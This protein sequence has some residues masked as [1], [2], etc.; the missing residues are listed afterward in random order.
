MSDEILNLLEEG[1]RLQMGGSY[2]EAE[3][4]YREVL[5]REPKNI[6]ALNLLGIVCINTDRAEE[7]VDFIAVAIG[8]NAGD[9]ESYT[10][11]GIAQKDLQRFEAARSSFEKA[12]RLNPRNP[13]IFNNLG[14]VQLALNQCEPAVKSF[15]AALQLDPNYADSL[16]NLTAALKETGQ[17]GGALAAA[18]RAIQLRPDFAEA[19]N[20]RGEVLFKQARFDD[21]VASYRKAVEFGENYVGAMINLSAALKETGDIAG[22]RGSL[23]EA[24]KLEPD[25]ARAYNN[26]GV[27]LEQLGDGAA[28]AAQF[29]EAIQSSTEYANAYYQLAQLR[30]QGLND[31]EVE[32]VRT[33]MASENLADAQRMPLAFAL[34]CAYEKRDD[35]DRSFE[36]L[37]MAQDIKAQENPYDDKMVGK[38]YSDIAA[39][40][41]VA[42]PDDAGHIAVDGPTPVFVLGMP[43][44]GTTLTE[45][46]LGSH[47]AVYGAGELSFMEDTVFE[48]KKITGKAYPHCMEALSKSQLASLGRLYLERIAA[49][50][51]GEPIVVDKTPM[52]F[53]Y[54]GFIAA[55]LPNARFIHC[56]RD[57]IDNCLSIFKLPFEKSHSYAHSLTALGQYFRHYSDLMQHWDRLLGD[58]ILDVQYENTVADVEK[59]SRS[60]LEFLELPFDDAVLQFHKAE[61]IV[62]TPSASQVR[63][64][65][66]SSSVERWRKYENHLRPLIE[67]LEG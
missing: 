17:L 45:Q 67:Q 30:G 23:D 62:K 43:R 59:Q 34:A 8:E 32:A 10:N 9:A 7:A 12:A 25:N 58:R 18:D 44:S 13:V 22:A 11:M 21:A 38:Y 53:Q 40:F 20:N 65:I 48:A 60:L 16:S 28:A 19:W 54:I 2:G 46:I 6:H 61:G 64:P 3:T 50:T 33:L 39:Q 1:Y 49:R 57:P 66:Y 29:R 52:N 26:M 41:S 14:N 47:A 63:Q 4:R 36:H 42:P 56:R 31:A 51:A 5:Q 15:R 35:Y 55:A 24:L 27:L 37:V